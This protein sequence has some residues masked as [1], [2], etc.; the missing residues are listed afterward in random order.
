[1]LRLIPLPLLLTAV[2]A[3]H[4]QPVAITPGEGFEVERYTVALRPDLAT[5][6]VAGTE[7][8][9]VRGTSDRV[10]QLAF[11]ANALRV[12]EATVNAAP[13]TTFS[14]G[15][16]LVFALPRALRRGERATLQFRIEGT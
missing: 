3:A 6:A 1:M 5:T 15:E 8:I 2:S 16:A 4:A 14:T 9:V 13:V 7:T 11:S 12:S 10:T